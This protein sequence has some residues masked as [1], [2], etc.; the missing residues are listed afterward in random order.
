MAALP[1]GAFAAFKLRASENKN[2]K[3]ARRSINEDKQP[4]FMSKSKS[5]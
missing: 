3:V 1:Q 5:K 2:L 4:R